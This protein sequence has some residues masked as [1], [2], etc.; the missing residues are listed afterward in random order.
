MDILE[1]RSYSAPEVPEACCRVHKTLWWRHNMAIDKL[2]DSEGHMARN[3]DYWIINTAQ[4]L[5]LPWAH[6]PMAMVY[7]VPPM[8]CAFKVC[9][10]N[11]ASRLP[12][13]ASC[14]W[15]GTFHLLGIS[16]VR[17]YHTYYHISCHKFRYSSDT[18]SSIHIH[19]IQLIY[20][21]IHILISYIQVCT[22][23]LH[24][25]RSRY[26]T[27]I[28]CCGEWCGEWVAHLHPHS[29]SSM[30]PQR[31]QWDRGLLQASG[32]SQWSKGSAPW[33]WMTPLYLETMTSIDKLAL[34][35]CSITQIRA[36][37]QTYCNIQQ[38]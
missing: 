10:R 20:I 18:V 3:M 16:I 28:W 7:L 29:I 1:L 21:Y 32:V 33:P 9:H 38:S 15:D 19:S 23:S 25:F 6:F 22:P 14:C 35:A 13:M 36:A 26:S 30:T 34:H 8:Q 17:K 31:A 12:D 24:S 5:F 37:M 4:V 2:R 11:L 27:M